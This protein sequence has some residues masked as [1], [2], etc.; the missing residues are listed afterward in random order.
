MKKI[1]MF[2]NRIC[3]E[4]SEDSSCAKVFMCYCRLLMYLIY[5]SIMSFFCFRSKVIKEPMVLPE[6][7]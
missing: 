5:C 3:H 2:Q 1:Q 6:H 7:E 4:I